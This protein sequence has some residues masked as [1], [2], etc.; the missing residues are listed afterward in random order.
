MKQANT[1]QIPR[2]RTSRTLNFESLENRR[3]MD[4]GFGAPTACPLADDTPALEL[5]QTSR[6]DIKIDAD[7]WGD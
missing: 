7:G 1:N 4:T 6:G 2:L 5:I 3:V